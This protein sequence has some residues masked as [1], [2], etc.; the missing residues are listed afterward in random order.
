MV[1]SVFSI[2]LYPRKGQKSREPPADSWHRTKHCHSNLTTLLGQES[3]LLTHRRCR[4]PGQKLPFHSCFPL[5]PLLCRTR[6]PLLSV[7]T[8]LSAGPVSW[9]PLLRHQLVWGW[10]HA[11]HNRGLCQLCRWRGKG[12]RGAVTE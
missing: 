8:A 9:S 5:V 2:R 3:F 7:L 4:G 1:T 12:G 6:F 10:G 11:E